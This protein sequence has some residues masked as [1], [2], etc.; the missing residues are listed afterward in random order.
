M[1]A[2]SIEGVTHHGMG[3][4]GDGTLVA[5]TLP[6]EV[7]EP[8]P[9]GSVRILTPSIARVAPPCRHYR[10]CGG[11]AMQHASEEFVAG[12]K[13]DIVRRALVAR[14]IEGAI[15]GVTT[16]SPRS[17]RRARLSGRRTKGGVTLGFHGRGSDRIVAIPDCRI[18]TPALVGALPAL[19]ELVRIAASRTSEVAL[20]VTESGEG[21]DVAIEGGHPLTRALREEVARWAADHAIARVV[22][23]GE[24]V[25]MRAAP[26]QHFG[27]A[28][29]LPPPGAFLQ[30]TAHG[31]AALLARVREILGGARRIVDLFAGCGT[32]ALPL[33]E[34]AT[35]HAV[36]GEATMIDALLAGWR[37]APGLGQVTGE[38]RDL[39][40]RPLLPEELSR[41]DAAVIDPPRAGAEAQVAA[42][43]RSAVPVIAMVSCNPVTFA[44][45][46]ATLI[47]A[48]YRMTPVLVVDQFRWSAHVE[49]VA[50]FAR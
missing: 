4:T 2:L 15:L 5:R 3:R 25:S 26:V 43:A 19:E 14:G 22:W 45:D 34:G 8:R 42:L 39:F 20:V 23:D 46:A 16:S 24:Q 37:Q 35:V 12:W 21:P 33:A 9:D 48:G 7:V 11:C 49:T 13:A 38:A 29:V 41:F 40:R 50:G 30:A 28:R 31:E 27:R 6:G 44:R 10:G 36:E 47:A 17:R 18:L 32:F 1:T